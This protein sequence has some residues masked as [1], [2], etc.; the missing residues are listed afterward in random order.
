LSTITRRMYRA[1]SA[2]VVPAGM[3]PSTTAISASKSR[4]TRGRAGARDRAGRSRRPS[5]PDRSA[6]RSR[7]RA[8][9]R[10]CAPAA[11]EGREYVA[12][13]QSLEMWARFEAEEYL[14][15]DVVIVGGTQPEASYPVG[16]ERSAVNRTDPILFVWSS[17]GGGR[18]GPKQTPEPGM[19]PAPQRKFVTPR[20]APDARSRAQAPV[21]A[22]LLRSGS[23]ATRR[24]AYRSEIKCRSRRGPAGR[25]RPGDL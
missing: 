24:L 16:G 6:D 18:A 8:A 9:A 19:S 17:P 25:A 1:A 14:R 13:G 23:R 7:N 11:P 10:R 15:L 3:S 21:A 12:N 22:G 4:P 5:R 20:A 2:A